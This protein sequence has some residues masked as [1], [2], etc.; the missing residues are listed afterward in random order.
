MGL[1]RHL[2]EVCEQRS[3][4]PLAS[5]GGDHGESLHR[6]MIGGVLK[7]NRTDR[8]IADPGQHSPTLTEG[9]LHIGY[10]LTINTGRWV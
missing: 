8:R 3:G 7:S 9:A 4:N 10:A 6:Q 1:A 2:F 5:G